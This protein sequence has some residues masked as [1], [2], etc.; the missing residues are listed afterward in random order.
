MGKTDS[1]GT[2]LVL[3][4]SFETIGAANIALGML[5]TNGIPCILENELI[6]SVFALPAASFDRVRLMVYERDLKEALRLLG[7]DDYPQD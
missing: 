5:R 4:R 2:R 3:A 1:D 7:P 6:A